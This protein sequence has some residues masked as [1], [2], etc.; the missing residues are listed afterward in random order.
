MHDESPALIHAYT[1]AQAI[2]DGVLIPIHPQVSEAGG[3]RV[4]IAFT[5][6]A[7]GAA[8]GFGGDETDGWMRAGAVLA[9]A[10]LEYRQAALRARM[11]LGTAVED[12]IHFGHD[13]EADTGGVE[14]LQ[15][16]ML[17]GPGD[18]G[19]MVGTVMLEGED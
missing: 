1:R 13:M 14:T 17:I 16:W 19:E 8:V 7:W 4:P 15:M 10:R 2:A 3:F 5:A 11:G 9:A 18:A 6:G 12:R